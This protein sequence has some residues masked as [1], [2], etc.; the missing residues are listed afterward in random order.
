LTRKLSP[1]RQQEL[2]GLYRIARVFSAFLSGEPD[3]AVVG[4]LMEDM[5]D[6]HPDLGLE[7]M[8][9]LRDDL[10]LPTAFGCSA[11]SF[12]GWTRCSETVRASASTR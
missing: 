5:L 12:A 6:A 11:S 9:Y 4:K 2:D 7:E 3:G 10:L 8:R 1:E